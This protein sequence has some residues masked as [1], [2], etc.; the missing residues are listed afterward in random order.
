[1]LTNVDVLQED[2]DQGLKGSP[3]CCALTLAIK[4]KAPRASSVCVLLGEVWFSGDRLIWTK[5]SR[6]AKKFYGDFDSSRRVAPQTFPID[7]PDQF[8][9]VHP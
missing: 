1:M 9:E 3:S 2:I 4:R 7:I 8:L 6:E 5:L